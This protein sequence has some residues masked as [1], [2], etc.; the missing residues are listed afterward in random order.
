ML[1]IVII[2]ASN[3]I[4]KRRSAEH[5]SDSN[6]LIG[7]FRAPPVRAPLIVSL[8]I[9]IYTHIYLCIYLFGLLYINILLTNAT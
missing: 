6:S 9:Y 2:M 4:R 5:D 1:A 7:F 8:Y 3:Y